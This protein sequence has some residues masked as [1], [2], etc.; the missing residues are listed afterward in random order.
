[1]AVTSLL[2]LVGAASMALGVGACGKNEPDGS[3][4]LPTPGAVTTASAAPSPSP[5]PPLTMVNFKGYVGDRLNYPLAGVTLD[6]V[7]GPQT[8]ETSVTGADGKFA[9][10]NPVGLP[11][12]VRLKREGY[13]EKRE[14]IRQQ[15]NP[16]GFWFFLDTLDG[17]YFNFEP[18]DYLLRFSLDLAEATSWINTRHRAQASH[19]KR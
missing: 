14:L 10:S 12:T 13:A 4:P 7:D 1:M 17:A 11:V 9:F 8:G 16:A 15:F 5:A 19:P 6:L 2:V 3:G 18:G